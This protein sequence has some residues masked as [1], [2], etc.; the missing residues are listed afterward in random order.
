MQAKINA[1]QTE[2]GKKYNSELEAIIPTLSSEKLSDIQTRVQNAL[3][4]DISQDL[5]DFL[6]FIWVVSQAEL[7]SR[8][9]LPE[10]AQDEVDTAILEIDLSVE[11]I[12]ESDKE[13]EV[14]QNMIGSEIKDFSEIFLD[15]LSLES[16]YEQN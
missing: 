1:A 7:L 8:S 9:S 6:S 2:Y 3:R 16:G 13:I 5:E 15:S 12:N 4:E 10:N 14:L 11:Q